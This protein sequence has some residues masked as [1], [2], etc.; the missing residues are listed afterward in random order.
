MTSI[1]NKAAKI[2]LVS[3]LGLGVVGCGGESNKDYFAYKGNFR[4]HVAYIGIDDL[5]RQIVVED[6]TGGIVAN[7]YF[8]DGLI[9]EIHGFSKSYTPLFPKNSQLRAYFSA[10]SMEAVYRDLFSQKRAIEIADS[11]RREEIADSV[12]QQMIDGGNE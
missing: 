4:G 1:F 7:D 8:N 11:L 3:L 9:D 10:D 2:G 12:K 5:R 6:S